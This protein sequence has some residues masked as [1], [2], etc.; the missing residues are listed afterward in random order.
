MPGAL[1]L[2]NHFK[3]VASGADNA[4]FA[5]LKRPASRRNCDYSNTP[6]DRRVGQLPI[7]SGRF[8]QEPHPLLCLVDPVFDQASGGYIFLLVA[9]LMQITHITHE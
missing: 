4:A 8:E 7:V 2:T 9:Y 5:E 6:H 1:P 3:K